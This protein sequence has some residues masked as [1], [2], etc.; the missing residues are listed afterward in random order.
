MYVRN[1][2]L[3]INTDRRSFINYHVNSDYP[4]VTKFCIIVSAILYENNVNFAKNH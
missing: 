4:I 2:Y 1:R 3:E